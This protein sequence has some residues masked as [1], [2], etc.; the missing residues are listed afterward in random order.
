METLDKMMRQE[1]PVVGD[2]ENHRMFIPEGFKLVYSI[3]DQPAGVVKHISMSINRPNTLPSINSVKYMMH[4]LGFSRPL[5]S[6]DGVQ[7]ENLGHGFQAINIL[8]L[9]T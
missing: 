4:A 1:I 9:Q 3:E 2:D 6:A 8:E 5:D 7:I